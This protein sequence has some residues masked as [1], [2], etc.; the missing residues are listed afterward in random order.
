M[1][2]SRR[3]WNFGPPRCARPRCVCG[4]CSP[5][6]AWRPRLSCSWTG[7][8]VRS[9]ARPGGCGPRRRAIPAPGA[10]RPSWGGTGGRRT[11]CATWC[12]TQ[13][14]TGILAQRHGLSRTT[15]ARW[16]SRI[17]A[18]GV[19]MGPGS[20]RSTVLTQ[21]AEAR[22][23]EFRRR[24]LLPLDDVPGC[25]RDSIPKL[26]RSSRHRCLERHGISRQA[27]P[28]PPLGQGSGAAEPQRPRVP[29]MD[30]CGSC[31]ESYA[32]TRHD[33][34]RTPGVHAGT[35]DRVV[36]GGSRSAELLP[37]RQGERA[38]GCLP[39]V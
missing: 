14:A 19:P 2:R 5:R 1:C 9:G 35:G 29:A 13:E 22:M 15:V 7:F 27:Q 25:L 11:R 23:V 28:V 3:R 26:T 31:C 10:S 30:Q 33:P 34:G 24:T 20:P 12:A 39:H 17:A 8:W 37:Q 4:R 16:R 6:L 38:S 36:Q 32:N 21:V 18:G